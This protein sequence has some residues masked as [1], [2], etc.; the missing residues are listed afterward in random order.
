M[1]DKDIT[2]IGASSAGLFAAYL[3]AKEGLPVRLYDQGETLG[4]PPRTLI[5]T[6]QINQVLGFVP[7]EAIINRI[8]HIELFSRNAWAKVSLQQP[9][10]V[11]ERE[12]F[13]RLLAARA[14]HEGAEI[15]LGYRF[16]GFEG[17]KDGLALRNRHNST[18]LALNLKNLRQDRVEHVRA[19]LLIG[20]DGAFSDV[21]RA[22]Q[23]AVR[24]TVAVLQAK[25]ALPPGA[26]AHTVKVW[27]DREDTRFFSWLIPES[28]HSA[29]AGLISESQGDANEKLQH[30]LS[31]HQ[32]E[33]QSYQAAQVPLYE[34]GSKP[35]A[36]AGGLDV[37]LVG[38]AAGQVKMTT[39]G[40]VVAGLRGAEAAAKAIAGQRDYGKELRELKRELDLHWL[41]R[42]VLDRFVDADYDRL[43]DLLNTRAKGILETHNRDEMARVL[44]RLLLAQPR[45]FL[46]GTKSFLRSRNVAEG[47]R[48]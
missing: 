1:N 45:W 40:G 20:A 21:A 32:L 16:L 6:S 27:F 48:S 11:L 47:F 17:D 14:R 26:D 30:F 19:R 31:K 12:K 13:I 23:R 7:S 4:P 25:V 36:R 8:H 9:D 42:G 35:W 29:A 15:E 28:N 2:I 44:W 22:A 18:G 43:L 41:I 37:L 38:D 24:A 39:V 33:A 34:F 46:L 10:L 3:L 5:V